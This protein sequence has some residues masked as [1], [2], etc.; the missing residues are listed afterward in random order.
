MGKF[1]YIAPSPEGPGV[2]V[3]EKGPDVIVTVY[4]KTN[5]IVQYLSK[6]VYI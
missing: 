3:T 6:Y 2:I 4:M 5:V 1:F